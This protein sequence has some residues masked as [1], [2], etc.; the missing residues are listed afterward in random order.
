MGHPVPLPL[1]SKKG[2]CESELQLS[3]TPKTIVTTMPPLMIAT[4]VV[5]MKKVNK[6]LQTWP[7][8]EL[9]NSMWVYLWTLPYTK[10]L[11]NSGR[12]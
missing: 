12:S 7:W 5:N 1:I 4:L 10:I 6:L 3:K 8:E 11:L 2:P 9:R